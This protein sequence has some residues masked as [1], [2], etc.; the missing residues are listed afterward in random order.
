[1]DNM[2]IERKAD[3][4]L[5]TVPASLNIEYLERLVDY[6]KVKTIASKSQATDQQIEQLAEEL[7]SAWWQQNKHRFIP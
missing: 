7:N 5:I 4:I 3:S 2:T 1:M 6:L